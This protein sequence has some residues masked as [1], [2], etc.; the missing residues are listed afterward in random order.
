MA[1]IKIEG[2][3]V[4]ALG[5]VWPGHNNQPIGVGIDV[6]DYVGEKGRPGRNVWGGRLLVVWGDKLIDEKIRETGGSLTLDGSVDGR[7][8]QP[9]KSRRRR[10]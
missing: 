1:P 9:T 5:A 2:G 10:W 6:R 7:T 3:G 8:Q 4:S